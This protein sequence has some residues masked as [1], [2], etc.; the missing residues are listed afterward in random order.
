MKGVAV[1]TAA[2]GTVVVDVTF[3]VAVEATVPSVD[4]PVVGVD[5]TSTAAV[6]E[7]INGAVGETGA[8]VDVTVSAVDIIVTAAVDASLA[9]TVK[10]L[11]VTGGEEA[12]PR[13]DVVVF[14]WWRLMEAV[15]AGGGAITFCQEA[16]TSV[17]AR[18]T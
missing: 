7:S 5:E 11:F 3:T 6:D 1:A 18:C 9:A 16:A 17:S 15:S 12:R 2:D 14:R 8:A 10:V 13:S 4:A